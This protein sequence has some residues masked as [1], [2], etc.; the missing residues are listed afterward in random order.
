MSENT[1]LST[2]LDNLDLDGLSS[3]TDHLDSSRRWEFTH[4]DV[5]DTPLVILT[6]KSIQ[7]QFGEAY[8]SDV[9]IDEEYHTVLFGGSVLVKQV[10]EA[11]EHLPVWAMVIKP[12]KYY[13]FENPALPQEKSDEPDDTPD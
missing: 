7:T 1:D 10:E 11:K 3:I 6:A 9:L 4:R 2:I 8:I 12:G 5:L 13:Q